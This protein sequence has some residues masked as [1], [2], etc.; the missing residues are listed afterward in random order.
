MSNKDVKKWVFKIYFY[1]LQLLFIFF[2]LFGFG[3]RCKVKFMSQTLAAR[4]TAL[5]A[6]LLMLRESG[7]LFHVNSGLPK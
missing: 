5:A 3:Q 6:C 1:F 2:F 7:V 4:R